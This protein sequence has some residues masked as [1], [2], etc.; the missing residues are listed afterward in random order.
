LISSEK[1]AIMDNCKSKYNEGG[2][3]RVDEEA[4]Y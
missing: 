2:L 1:V 3:L 4:G